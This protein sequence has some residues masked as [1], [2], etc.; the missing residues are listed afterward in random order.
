[1]TVFVNNMTARKDPVGN[2][3]LSYAPL[4]KQQERSRSGRSRL[5]HSINTQ[6]ESNVI[7]TKLR[8]M[9]Q[10]EWHWI[11]NDNKMWDRSD[12]PNAIALARSNGI[13]PFIAA[14]KGVANEKNWE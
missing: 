13:E 8:K 4:K 11:F 3:P 14:M 9:I 7:H 2:K 1:M 6:T 5:S 10:P 12:S